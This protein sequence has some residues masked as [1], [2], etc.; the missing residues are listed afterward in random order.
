M[1]R[2]STLALAALAL[3]TPG[4]GS[5]TN[6]L[7]DGGAD[8]ALAQ[9]ERD[10]GQTWTVRFHADVHTPAFLDGKTPPLAASPR[11]AE[12]AG[13]AFLLRYRG[14]FQINSPDDEL[15]TVTAL[16]DELGMTHVRFQQQVGHVPVWRDDLIVHFAADGSLVRVNGRFQPIG[17]V[18]GA[19]VRTADDARA[20]ALADA[21]AARADVGADSFTTLA[22][23]L[24]IYPT[25]AS[26]ARLAW[27]VETEV[28]DVARPMRLETFVDASDGK[29]LRRADTLAFADGS[30]V[31]VFGDLRH[32]PVAERRG[33]YWLEDATHGSPPQKIYSGAGRS[34]LPGG[35][36]SSK[37]LD[38]WDEDGPGHG[39]AVDAQAYLAA[40]WDYFAQVHGRSGWDGQG[41]GVRATVHFGAGAFFDGKQLAFGDGGGDF[42]PLAGA[43]DVVAHEF[44]HGVVFHT[45]ALP[46]QGESGALAEGI[47]DVFAALASERLSLDDPWRFGV[48]V[49]HPHGAPRAIRDATQPHATMNPETMDEYLTTDDD[50]G[51]VHVNATIVSHAAWLMTENGGL[52]AQTASRIWYRALAR[53]LTARA[54]FLD[55][56]DATVA[57]AKDLGADAKAV[58]AAWVAVRVVRE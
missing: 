17:A 44:T 2:L 11:D 5:S 37:D 47:A 25:S 24:W 32:F 13:R 34:K 8:D 50:N 19:P 51:G 43:L 12:R 16:T 3:T 58:R 7:S 48:R 55:A 40:A 53:Y 4:C 10:T 9:L 35:E 26:D 27:R 36:V 33:R 14:L 52:G 1:D 29:I 54:T 15:A 28:N 21:R 18:D 30:G 42:A 46:A 38:H 6:A 57:A 20:A 41:K 23:K 39:S 49:Y 22:P 45:A 56:A 31:G